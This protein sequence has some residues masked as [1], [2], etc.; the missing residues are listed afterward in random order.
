MIESRGSPKTRFCAMRAAL[1]V[2]AAPL[3]RVEVCAHI[4]C[5]GV[6]VHGPAAMHS[7]SYA[8]RGIIR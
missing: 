3:R 7:S 4:M 6:L 8:D 5:N 1:R 2:D